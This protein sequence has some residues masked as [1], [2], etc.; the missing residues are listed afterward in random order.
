M[1]IKERIFISISKVFPQQYH[2][3]LKQQLIYA[4]EKTSVHEW[5]GN[6]FLLS[7]ML[8]IATFLVPFAIFFE[9][10]LLYF[11]AGVGAF[12]FGM[13]L[14]Y[15]I[16]Y[17]KAE[18]RRKRVE[19]S[20][21]DMLQLVA[22][23]LRAGMTPFKALQVSARKEFGP[24]K[25]E[26]ET[27][28]QK[29]MGTASFS[30]ALLNISTRVNSDI[31][32]RSLKLFTTAMKSGGRL[33]QLLEELASD[34]RATQELKNELVTNT[35][36]YTMF[37]MFTVAV[38]TPLLLSIAVHFLGIV[39]ELQADTSVTSD[40][41]GLGFLTGDLEIT[42]QFMTYVSYG[43]MLVTSV[44]ASM[45]LG[46]ISDGQM[47]QGFRMAPIIAGVSFAVFFI[48]KFFVGN[49]LAGIG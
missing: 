22:A 27:A 43:Q 18:D 9:F 10:K 3:F 47:R 42:T 33:A 44:L 48:S 2:N 34:I 35:K 5:I 31:L 45:L 36:T 25:E 8:G 23:N 26:I 46:V 7:L 19:K 4:G 32:D 28:S 49:F 24:L 13:L 20:L 39:S 17:F 30:G 40:D 11:F 38:G 16:I 6:S 12:I 37:I 14:S 41:F 1:K 29:A 21:P 15:L